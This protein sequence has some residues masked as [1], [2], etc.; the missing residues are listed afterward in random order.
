MSDPKT[1]RS[2]VEDEGRKGGRVASRMRR[3]L[4]STV[5]LAT[6]TSRRA[7]AKGKGVKLRA[8]SEPA[9][10]WETRTVQK[11]RRNQVW[12]L[13][14]H[15]D[16]RDLATLAQFRYQTPADQ[17]GPAHLAQLQQAT[18]ATRR[19]QTDRDEPPHMQATATTPPSFT[20][21]SKKEAQEFLRDFKR[22]TA[23]L[24][25]PLTRAQRKKHLANAFEPFVQEDTAAWEWWQGLTPEQRQDWDQIEALFNVEWARPRA[26]QLELGERMA[27]F[28]AKKLTR[29]ELDTRVP[30]TGTKESRWR[31]SEFAEELERL[32]NKTGVQA[33]LLIIEALDLLPPGVRRIMRKWSDQQQGGADW[34]DFCA[35][36]GGLGKTAIDVEQESFD[37]QARH[38]QALQETT[39]LLERQNEE[40]K[41]LQKTVAAQRTPSPTRGRGY[42]RGLPPYASRE[43]S[44]AAQ[45]RRW[46]EL[47]HIDPNPIAVT[48]RRTPPPQTPRAEATPP[49]ATSTPSAAPPNT[50]SETRTLICFRCGGEGHKV[51]GCTSTTPLPAS[52]QEALVNRTIRRPRFTPGTPQSATPTG[53]RFWPPPTPQTPSPAE[54]PRPVYYLDD[55][56]D[57]YNDADED[58]YEAQLALA[59]VT[60]YGDDEGKGLETEQ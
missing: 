10:R 26:A 50:P 32:G 44:P 7:W 20:G 12:G 24:A 1:D 3:F 58:D 40:I 52:E 33:D 30:I 14:D 43:S 41:Q 60:F 16:L 27:L 54:R 17:I 6:A 53:H 48:Y 13:E 49:R 35:H 9:A 15:C 59:H 28:R 4:S 36:L 29:E 46:G 56:Y 57:Q 37:S 34:G 19:N 31:H 38:A 51:Y 42:G 22:F 47:E 8:S 18:P 39:A 21:E 2:E 5:A 25:A 55:V 23:I 45:A 11:E